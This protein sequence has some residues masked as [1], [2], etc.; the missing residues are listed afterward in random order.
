M[1]FNF[2]T[3]LDYLYQ[4]SFPLLLTVPAFKW[5]HDH[6]ICSGLFKFGGGGSLLIVISGVCGLILRRFYDT[7]IV[8]YNANTDSGF[9][10]YSTNLLSTY[11][12][13]GF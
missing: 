5:S 4:V 10:Y 6:S 3:V 12:V 9:I 11:Y 2:S 8:N 1:A 7:K 13:L